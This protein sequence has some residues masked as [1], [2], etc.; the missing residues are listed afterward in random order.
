MN[1]EQEITELCLKQ[2]GANLAGIAIFGSYNAGPYVEGVSD[3]DVNIYL[4]RRNGMDL[5]QEKAV[6]VESAKALKLSVHHLE[7]LD[8]GLDRIYREGSWT[9]WIT[10]T[11]GSKFICATPAFVEFID[12]IRA[13]D[14]AQENLIEYIKH[15]D[16]LE[17]AGYLRR[18]S[19]W[20]L[21]KCLYAHIRRKLQILSYRKTKQPEFDYLKCL[22]NIGVNA[23]TKSLLDNLAKY[24]E[25]RMSLTGEEAQPYFETAAMLSKMIISP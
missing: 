11:C 14:I 8:V 2:F 21:T 9:S 7:T 23:A 13:K 16:E 6:L 12:K 10:L 24:Y 4:L 1:I 19:D 18:I 5:A 20:D 22:A 25:I 17:L 15:K 3:I